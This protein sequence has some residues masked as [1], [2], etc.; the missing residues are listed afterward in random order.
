MALSVKSD[1]DVTIILVV[2]SSIVTMANIFAGSIAMALD[3]ICVLLS[4]Y[5]FIQGC[6]DYYH[7][8]NQ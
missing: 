6:G 1:L 8:T 7:D 4:Y 3:N 2:L 5:S